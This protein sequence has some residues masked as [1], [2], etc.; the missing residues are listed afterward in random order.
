METKPIGNAI[1]ELRQQKNMTSAELADQLGVDARTVADWETGH[2]VPDEGQICA[3]AELFDIA[4]EELAEGRIPSH[5]CGNSTEAKQIEQDQDLFKLICR[6]VALAMGIAV[7]VLSFM[8]R[9]DPQNA[10]TM[11]GIGLTCL[12][13]SAF[14]RRK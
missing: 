11:L 12:G 1:S 14:H 5:V 3:L 10:V 9:M 2:V 7:T 13:I 8:D 4:A 6:T